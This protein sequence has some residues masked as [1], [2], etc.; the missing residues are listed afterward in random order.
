MAAQGMRYYVGSASAYLACGSLD[1]ASEK[2]DDS[3]GF[4]FSDVQLS[5]DNS[6]SSISSIESNSE[7]SSGNGEK[8]KNS[9]YILDPE[10]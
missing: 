3:K 10:K 6:K 2:T 5:A 9:I 8:K 4:E 7:A 1:S